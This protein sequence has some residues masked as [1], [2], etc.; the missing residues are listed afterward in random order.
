MVED[1]NKERRINIHI[2]IG[3]AKKDV[4]R[5]FVLEKINF[6]TKKYHNVQSIE[7][8]LFWIVI[9]M[10]IENCCI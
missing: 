1:M 3:N 8:K 6:N 10:I 7:Y 4:I 5:I 9:L 2:M